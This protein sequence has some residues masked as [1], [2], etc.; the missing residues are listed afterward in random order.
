MRRRAEPDVASFQGAREVWLPRFSTATRMAIALMGSG[1]A[2][3]GSMVA[4]SQ[5]WR[6]GIQLGPGW[7]LAVAVVAPLISTAALLLA[8]TGT[9]LEVYPSAVFVNHQSSSA[10]SWSRVSLPRPVSVRVDPP[11]GRRGVARIQLHTDQGEAVHLEVSVAY[12]DRVA[13]L[14]QWVTAPGVR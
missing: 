3:G 1:I 4:Y 13:R 10:W 11:A 12:L 6:F 14:T 9:R 8:R 7:V 2:V 5:G